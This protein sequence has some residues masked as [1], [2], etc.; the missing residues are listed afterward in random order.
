MRWEKRAFDFIFS[1]LGLVFLFPFFLI[2]ALMIKIE[3]GGPVLFI[4]KRVGYKGRPF[5]MYKFRTMVVDAEKKGN[6]LTVGGDPRITKSGR[7]LRKFKLDELPQL[8][9]VIKGEMSLVGPRPEVEKYVNLYTNEQREVLNLYP[10]I[11]DPASIEYVN[12]SELLAQ[13]SDPE[14]LYVE[15][16]MP[17]KIRINLEYAR[18]ASWWTD[19]LVIVKTLARII[20]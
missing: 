18:K 14:K 3:D 15:K 10:G 6:L 17:E 1:T 19:F 12:E 11:T 9:N 2:I 5:F 7:L 13:S 4:Q 8:I 20:S 16:I